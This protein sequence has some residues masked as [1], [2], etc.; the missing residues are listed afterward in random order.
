[1]KMTRK[2]L[3]ADPRWG[4]L[5]ER[6]AFSLPRFAVEVCGMNEITWQQEKIGSEISVPGC[7]VSV[8]SGHGVGKTR[9]SGIAALWHLTCYFKS[10]T[11]FTAP[12][13]DQLRKQ[14]W[15]EI[16]DMHAKMKE[17]EFAWLAEHIEVMEESV[18]IKGFK[19]SWWV[20]ARTAPKGS[21]ENLAGAHRDWLMVWAD[22]ASGIPDANFE[23]LLGAMSDSRNRFVMMSQ[24][25]KPAGYF[26]DSHHSKSIGMGGI[27]TAI[28]LNSEQ[29]PIV[30]PESIRNWRVEYDYQADSL[31]RCTS[32][33][34]LVKV[35]GRFPDKSD[36]FLLGRSEVEACFGRTVIDPEK[37]S[38]GYMLS[39]DVGAGEYRDR[40]VATIAMVS[41]Y[42]DTGPDARRVQIVSVP[43]RS[44]STN[45]Q[46]FSGLVLR[47]AAELENVTVLVDA[48]G[49]GIAVCQNL[50]S[51][52]LTAVKRVKW[53]EP[54]FRKENKGR[55]FNL[56]AQASWCCA[57][58]I[59]DGRLGI[60]SDVPNKRD[61]L[62]QASR[63]P[64]HFDEKARYCI[65]KKEDM[66]SQGIP[67]PDDFDAI[68][69][70]FLESADF[71]LSELNQA[72]SVAVADTARS[73]A[74][75]LFSGV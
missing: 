44:N 65:A 74:A 25:T 16:A 8:A 75:D 43:I 21:P 10:N 34:Y 38:F 36:G 29:S 47:Q 20:T 45:I 7:R 32:P 56:R 64:Y 28:S 6:C 17:G 50:E 4:T 54:C 72:Q 39:V 59:K 63:I 60:A 73:K 22:E 19:K 49:M 37:D 53:G 18:F 46:D 66:R 33:M 14:V 2:T 61:L 1:M 12:K 42:G 41:G 5:V 11:I 58:A 31:G 24:P 26:Y 3:N 15:M 30:S 51:N 52:G 9:L 67:S 69:F 68:C 13:I 48:G 35:L 57:R 70:L 27:W 62:D 55:F 71:M 40:S 23:V